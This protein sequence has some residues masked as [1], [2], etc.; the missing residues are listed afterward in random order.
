MNKSFDDKGAQY[1]W[2]ATSLAMAAKCPR[3]YK[4]KM[5]DG[6]TPRALS[7]DLLFGICFATALETYHRHLAAHGDFDQSVMAA[8][9]AA[10]VQSWDAPNLRPFAFMDSAKTRENLIRSVVWYTEHYKDDNMKTVVLANGKPAVE[11]SFTMPIDNG[12]ML[13]G[14]MDRLV[15]YSNSIY[16]QDQ[17]TTKQALGAFY[18]TQYAP[19]IQMTLYP[20]VG[21]IIYKIA[22]SGVIVDAA[23]ILVGATRFERGF[24][25]STETQLSEFYDEMLELIETTRKA[26][27]ENHFPMRRT[28]CNMYRGCEFRGVCS[29]APE[30]RE[31]FLKADFDK[32]PSWDPMDRR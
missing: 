20:F 17:K 25:H 28:S 27:L 1:V 10:L 2:D 19:N 8:V 15:E 21:K 5:I 11:L 13:A 31:S 18:F 6:W 4:Y 14:H 26:T 7:V 23:Q 22:V 16:V 30:H 32:K 3:Y 12:Y 29:R 24:V 9:R